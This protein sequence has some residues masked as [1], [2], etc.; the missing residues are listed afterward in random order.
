M[1]CRTC[2]CH[3]LVGYR[4]LSDFL[5]YSTLP[6][7]AD[8]L[9]G[10]P[11]LR[12]FDD[13]SC[14]IDLVAGDPRRRHGCTAEPESSNCASVIP[15]MANPFPYLLIR[16]LVYQLGLLRDVLAD[17]H[18]AHRG[19]YNC[20]RAFQ[21]EHRSCVDHART[22]FGRY[23]PE[24]RAPLCH[25]RRMFLQHVDQVRFQRRFLP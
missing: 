25:G 2:I 12:D 10:D 24:C 11:T 5:F 7:Y 8:N 9:V 21:D 16:R 22:K 20:S 23:T 14:V 6:P 15:S 4:G 3:P 13:D 19:L 1:F 18:A 17:H